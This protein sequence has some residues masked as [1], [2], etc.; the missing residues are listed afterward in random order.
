MIGFRVIYIGYICVFSLSLAGTQRVGSALGANRPE[1]AKRSCY[2]GAMF[3]ACCAL[4]LGVVITTH[5]DLF[6]RVFTDDPALIEECKSLAPEIAFSQ[7][8][9]TLADYFIPML[10]T[11]GRPNAALAS[12]FLSSWFGHVPIC[13]V[14][15][16]HMYRH[17]SPSDRI[18]WLWTGVSIGYFAQCTI[19]FVCII[20]SDWPAL[21][22]VA[23]RTNEVHEEEEGSVENGLAARL[24]GPAQPCEERAGD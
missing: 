12:S 14:L 3:A 4:T 19:A 18:R 9:M 6:A 1:A 23:R 22:R 11:Q 21:A 17:E 8:F 20:C 5:R 7:F 24:Q 2:V 15:V 10:N 16:F 13:Y